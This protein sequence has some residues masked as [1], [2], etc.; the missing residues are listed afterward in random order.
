MYPKQKQEAWWPNK[1][2]CNSNSK[3]RNRVFEEHNS[4]TGKSTTND[5]VKQE[6]SETSGI[7]LGIFLA[8]RIFIY[9]GKN[10]PDIGP[11]GLIFNTPEK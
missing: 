4:N 10:D 1:H 8:A 3:P 7:F 11:L 6:W 2:R 9:L 5:H